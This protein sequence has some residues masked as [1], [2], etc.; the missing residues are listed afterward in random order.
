M[1]AVHKALDQIDSIYPFV[2]R[3][4]KA[5]ER[6]ES[7]FSNVK[8]STTQVKVIN[9]TLNLFDCEFIIFTFL[10]LF[11]NSLFCQLFILTTFKLSEKLRE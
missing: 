1:V 9:T 2:R 8:I 7:K 11:F 10:L 5:Q 3:P 6:D 4:V